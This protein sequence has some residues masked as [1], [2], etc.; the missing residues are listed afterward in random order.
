MDQ[1]LVLLCI[2][3]G[4]FV[5]NK[6]LSPVL[7]S[8]PIVINEVTNEVVNEVVNEEPVQNQVPVE[9][10]VYTANGD[11]KVIVENQ[12][13]SIMGRHTKTYTKIYEFGSVPK[14]IWVKIK[15]EELRI[16]E[17]EL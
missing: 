16:A 14:D 7:K 6:V 15:E 11:K 5:I 10:L 3:I 17:D 9:N 12:S 2:L 4:I 13:Y 1:I 8:K